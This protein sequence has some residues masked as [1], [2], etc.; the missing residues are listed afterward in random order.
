L[1]ASFLFAVQGIGI[2]QHLVVRRGGS[3]T[4]E[5]WVITG[6]LILMFLPGLN[7]VVSVGLPLFG[8]SELWIDYK[9]GESYESNTEP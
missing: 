7:I 9:R 8:M 5:R 1:I 4:A 6:V 2:L 3:P